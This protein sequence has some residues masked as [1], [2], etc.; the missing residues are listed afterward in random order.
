MGFFEKHGKFTDQ[1]GDYSLAE[2]GSF[3]TAGDDDAFLWAT[4]GTRI[5]RLELPDT[6]VNAA[7]AIPRSGRWIALACS[8]AYLSAAVFA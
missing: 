1:Q 7:C 4:D 8:A 5:A 3:V 2:D 6:G